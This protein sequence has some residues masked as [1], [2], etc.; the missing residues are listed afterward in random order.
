M[1]ARYYGSSLGRFMAVDP[2]STGINWANPQTWNRF[3]YALNNPLKYVDPDGR[4]I[5]NE[6]TDPIAHLTADDALL[7]SPIAQDLHADPNVTV[8]LTNGTLDP[9]G[10]GEYGATS[11]IQFDAESGTSTVLVTIDP[12]LAG[13]P[14]NISAL[15]IVELSTGVLMQIDPEGT[16]EDA[17]NARLT[18]EKHPLAPEQHNVARE[19]GQDIGRGRSGAAGADGQGKR[20]GGVGSG[21]NRRGPRYAGDRARVLVDGFDVSY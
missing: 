4:T 17:A 20:R 6:L 9:T 12:V 7:F 14:H 1:L 13:E 2:V 16:A 8:T 15:T 19:I 5:V 10:S 18:G 11:D 21:L 3:S